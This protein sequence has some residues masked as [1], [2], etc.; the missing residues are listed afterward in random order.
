MSQGN[1]LQT[2][3]LQGLLVQKQ[4]VLF[5]LLLCIITKDT[6]DGCLSHFKK[7]VVLRSRAT[8]GGAEACVAGH[9][10]WLRLQGCGA[11]TS[12]PRERLTGKTESLL[13]V[14]LCQ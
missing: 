4:C 6:I 3:T 14:S 5:L 12:Q 9:A 10:Q 1:T 2:H 7:L 13:Q 8:R 11:T